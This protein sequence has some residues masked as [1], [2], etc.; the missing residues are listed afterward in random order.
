M[1]RKYS[2]C[3]DMPTPIYNSG[4]KPSPPEKVHKQEDKN[5][6]FGKFETDDVILAIVA[7]M[8]FAN[9]CDDKLLLLVLAAVFLS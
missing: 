9:D 6:I 1:Y 2:S 4:N 7:L 5:K 8:L 3:N